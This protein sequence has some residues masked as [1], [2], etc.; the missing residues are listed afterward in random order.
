MAAELLKRAPAVTIIVL[1]MYN[2]RTF[3]DDS[4]VKTHRNN[5]N[6]KLGISKPADLV[7]FALEHG[8]A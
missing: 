2:H 8:L 1:T 4:T 3:V 7:K 6:L 5:I